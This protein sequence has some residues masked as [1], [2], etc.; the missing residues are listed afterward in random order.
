MYPVV[1]AVTDHPSA[2]GVELTGFASAGEAKRLALALKTGAL[3]ARFV[4][5]SQRAAG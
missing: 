5:V 4:V 1:S 3:P 2:A